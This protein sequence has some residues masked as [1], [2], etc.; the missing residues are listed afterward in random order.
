MKIHA[1]NLRAVIKRPGGRAWDE[2]GRIASIIHRRRSLHHRCV[3]KMV[4][5]SAQGRRLGT[6]TTLALGALTERKRQG[7]QPQHVADRETEHS[8]PTHGV[9]V[10][11]G[12]S[13]PYR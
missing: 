12:L 10:A 6:L 2:V 9:P 13:A 7:R 11:P 4:P 3:R 8:A 5:E 1:T